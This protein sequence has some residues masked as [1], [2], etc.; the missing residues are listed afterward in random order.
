MEVGVGDE[1]ERV[2]A[3]SGAS[4]AVAESLTGGLVSSRI[5]A[6]RGASDFFLGG[7]VAYAASTKHALLGVSPGPVVRQQVATQMANGI[8]ALLGADVGIGIT[9]VGG[10]GPQ[11]GQPPGTVF[12]SVVGDAG[13]LEAHHL[14]GGPP[15]DVCA[16][17]CDRTIELLASLL[18]DGSATARDQAI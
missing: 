16:A 18:A 8:R 7:V 2:I 5:A 12:L 3:E 14:L 10:P 11:E 17:A 13:A 6:I 15:T 1:R 4:I 9:G